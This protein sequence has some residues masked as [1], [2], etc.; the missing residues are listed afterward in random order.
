MWIMGLLSNAM[1]YFLIVLSADNILG[2][3]W[4]LLRLNFVN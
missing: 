3:S 2:F 4:S 1:S